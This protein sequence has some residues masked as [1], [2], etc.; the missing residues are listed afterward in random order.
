MADTEAHHWW[1]AG[2]RRI[3]AQLINSLRLP[4]G[5]GILE[6]G[7][8]TGGNLPMLSTFGKVSALEMDAT[9]CTIARDNTGGQIDI[10]AGMF[11]GENA[12]AGEKFDLICLFDVL[13]HLEQDVAAL[14][15][16]K[17]LLAP[18]GKILLTVP[19]YQWLWSG[20][21][22][23]LHHKRRYGVAELLNKIQ[24]SGLY[25]EK[26][27]HFNTFLFPLAV[28]VRLQGRIFG[29]SGASGASVPPAAINKLFKLVFS[30]ERYLLPLFN[31][32]F[33]VSLLA[34]LS[35]EQATT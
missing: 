28:I 25:P 19:A 21:D 10:R 14:A 18:G 22:V 4:A 26:M 24:I 15:A 27:S 30:S 6:V 12:F 1:F 31:L 13:E 16:V 32:P 8:G 34:L 2:R 11:P 20:H 23:F 29:S 9:A 33:G 3:L 5:A 7:C 17:N 35:A